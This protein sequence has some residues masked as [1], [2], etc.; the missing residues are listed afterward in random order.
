MPGFTASI[1]SPPASKGPLSLRSSFSTGC[2]LLILAI[3]PRAQFCSLPHRKP[4]ASTP[5]PL[6]VEKLLEVPVGSGHPHETH[7]FHVHPLCG[8]F[9]SAE[10]GDDAFLL[11]KLS[12]FKKIFILVCLCVRSRRKTQV[13]PQSTT[14][15][16]VE[17]VPAVPML[18]YRQPARGSRRTFS[19]IF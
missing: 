15:N 12:Y 10:P 5:S 2:P 4:A 11:F 18:C 1:Q 7:T 3:L 8:S 19:G 17:L 9:S 13:S 14:L 16:S 6:E